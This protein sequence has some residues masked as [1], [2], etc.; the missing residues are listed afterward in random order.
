MK[1]ITTAKEK[2]LKKVRSAL[3]EKRDNPYPQLENLPL[4]HDS[5]ELLEVTFAEELM[6]VKGNFVFCEDE[7]HLIEQLLTIAQERGWHKMY[8]WEPQLQN[9]LKTYEFPFYE[10]DKDFDQADAS[11]TLCEA[12][13]A[14]NGSIMISNG[15][16]AGRRLSIYPPAHLVVAYTSQLVMDL[17]D[18]F[19]IIKEKYG[20][21]I[22]SM[23]SNI[24]GPSRTAD[25]EKTLVLGAHGPKELFV[26]LLD[27]GPPVS[28]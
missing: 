19:K 5:D 17:K 8:C 7:I 10:T 6:A 26:F 24:T 1:N 2:L 20:Q 15:N 25:I 22:P 27:G 18:G 11:I 13:I 3:L 28:T 4:Y 21:N 16:A 23:I 9:L 14:R 12:L